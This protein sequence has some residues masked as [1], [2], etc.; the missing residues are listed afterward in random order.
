MRVE[1]VEVANGRR[2]LAFEWLP[3]DP[4]GVLYGFLTVTTDA[5]FFMARYRRGLSA[6][7]VVNGVH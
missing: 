3:T 4:S 1:R 6:L 2:E 7:V 5:R